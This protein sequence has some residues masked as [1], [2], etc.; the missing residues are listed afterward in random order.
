MSTETVEA[1]LPGGIIV[2]QIRN[3]TEKQIVESG[4]ICAQLM[5]SDGAALALSG[6][7]PELIEMMVRLVVRACVLEGNYYAATNEKGEILGY[8]A[9]MPKGK[10]LFATEEQRN[11]G[12][13]EY[14]SRLSEEAKEY[15]KKVYMAEF[16]GFVGEC[17][18]PFKM[19]DVWWTHHLMV[20]PEYQR[21]GIGT[22][23]IRLSESQALAAGDTVAIGATKQ[24]NADIYSRLG[25][26]VRGHKSMKSPWVDWE[27]WILR[28]EPD[29][30]EK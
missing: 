17:L 8:S 11:L 29:N 14:M 23:L 22:A 20:R 9:V 30:N 28:L 27:M 26:K 2:R 7:D 1:T 18:A 4:E 24:V 19:V 21:R 25:Y 6:G 3:P 10:E 15:Y 16:P 12:L 5:K 13:N